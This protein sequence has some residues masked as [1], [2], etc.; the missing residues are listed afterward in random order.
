GDDVLHK[1][2][3]KSFS[4]IFRLAP[5]VTMASA[6]A[7]LD[8]LSKHLDQSST[9][10]ADRDRKGRSVHLVPGGMLLP[11]PKEVRPIMY[12]L[13]GTL[14]GLMLTI[15]CM[16]LANMLLAKAGTRRREIAI[17]LA[18]GASRFRLIRQL[19]TES[20]IL[21]LG[22]GV[23]GL[24]FAFWMTNMVSTMKLPGSTPFQFD[25]R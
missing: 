13:W 5:G 4:A 21:S 25:I 2:E 16:N 7:S 19:V 8:T 1:R 24:I 14:V 22:G 18:V 15:A 3:Q 17:R 12:A 20:V 11:I 10:P 6:E 23:V 9:D